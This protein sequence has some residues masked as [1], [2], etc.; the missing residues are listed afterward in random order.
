MA[1]KHRESLRE[2]V[3]LH[4]KVGQFFESGKDE[5]QSAS[6]AWVPPADLYETN[7]SIMLIMELSGV[8]SDA[9]KIDLWENY[10]T[11]SG[12]RLLKGREDSYLCME[13]SYGPFQRTF[14]LPTTV[15][16]NCAVAE[17]KFGV[18]KISMKKRKE[19]DHDFVRVTIG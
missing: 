11:V 14:R 4:D 15:E 16:E 10:I 9:V 8:E 17:F 13:R 2:L 1:N 3:V 5:V 12:E 6:G 7:D 19:P 18:L